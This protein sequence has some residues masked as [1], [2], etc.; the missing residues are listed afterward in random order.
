MHQEK[1]ILILPQPV[2]SQYSITNTLNTGSVGNVFLLAISKNFHH[3]Y[4]QKLKLET[5]VFFDESLKL[6]FIHDF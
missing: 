3:G 4:L 2:K 6:L 1:V 5:T